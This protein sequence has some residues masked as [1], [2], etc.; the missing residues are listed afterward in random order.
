MPPFPKMFWGYA[1]ETATLM[2]NR[3]PSKSVEK[4]PHELWY[5][6]VPNISFLKIWGCEA[7]V[8]R[9]TSDKLGPKI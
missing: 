5:G 4:T 6:I 9:M 1:L 2:I 8:K 3:V 7:Y